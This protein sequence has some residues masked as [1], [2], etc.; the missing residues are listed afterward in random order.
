MKHKKLII[1]F[2]LLAASLLLSGCS[3]RSTTPSSWPGITIVDNIAYVAFNQHVYGVQ[4]S[5]GTETTRLPSEPINGSTTFFHAPV[6]LDETTLLVGDY[7]K[8]IYTFNTANR[9]SS[10]FFDDASGRWIGP[11]IVAEDTI[12]APN[13]DN[14]LY[15]LDL[16]GNVKWSFESGDPIWASPLINDD[17]LYLASMDETLYA[18]DT[19]NGSVVWEA[20]LGGTMVNNAFLGEDDILYIGTFNSEVLALDSDNGSILWRF[21]TDDW[22]WGSPVLSEGVLYVTDL[23]GKVYAIDPADQSILWQYKGTG[24][25]SGSVLIHEGSIYF[26]TQGGVIYCLNIEGTLRWQASLGQDA[27]EFAGTPV[28]AGDSSI[29]IGALEAEGMLYAYST[30]GTLQWQ[31]MPQN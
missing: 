27:G 17:L 3:G 20:E 30:E 16:N 21:T 4:T 7:K 12:F 11:P 19:D 29:L 15:A 10:V 23:S 25:I 6:L 8:E 31:Y 22:V 13:T 24:A 9:T 28:A 2:S 18:L 14:F 1:L 5:N 26:A